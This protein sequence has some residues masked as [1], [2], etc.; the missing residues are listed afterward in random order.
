VAN[1]TGQTIRGY[2]I[3]ERIGS[4]GYGE[5]YRATQQSVG[6]DVAIKVIL[7]AYADQPEFI[8]NFETEARLVAQLEHPA[9]VP[10][11]DYWNDEQGAFLVMR[12]I[13]GGSLRA[14][15]AKQGALPLVR[16]LRVVEQIA[17]ALQVSHEAGVVHRDLKPDNILIDERGNAYLT[18]FGIAKQLKEGSD[19]ASD[20]IKGTFAYLSPEQIQQTTPSAQTDIYAL[21]IILYE[22][23]TGEHPFKDATVMMMV[24]KHLQDPLPIITD[25]R[26]DL[27][28]GI[29][30]VIGRA[31]QKDP[32]AR[33]DSTLAF[34]TDLKQTIGGS[35]P[36][37]SQ[38]IT[39]PPAPRR[40]S[41]PEQRNRY[42]MLQN[43]RK[44]WVEG[45]LEN[46]L[47]N[48]VMLDLDMKSKSGAVDNPWDTL[49]RTPTGDELLSS[50][51]AL[52]D[53]FD[54]M[55]G[56]LLILGDPGGGKTTSLLSL[57]R[58]LLRR[59]DADDHHPIPIILNI[60]SWGDKQLALDEWLVEELNS[61]YQVPRKVGAGW[62]A[63]DEV[64]LLLDGLD[65][66]SENARD[67]CV[68]AINHFRSEHGFVDV[69]VCSRIKDYEALSH[70]L[71]LNG[72]IIIQ[73]LTDDQIQTYLNALGA[74]VA[75]VRDL[76]THDE[77]LREL[78]HTPLMLSIM[79]LA[80]RG[81]SHDTIPNFDTL[82]AQRQHLFS[83]YVERMFNR[84]AIE[85][86]YTQPKTLKYLS[87]LA[88]KMQERATSVFN[89]EE[90]Q[91]IVIPAKNRQEFYRRVQAFHIGTTIFT[92]IIASIFISIAF[93]FPLWLFLIGLGLITGF[94]TGWSYSNNQWKRQYPH[95]LTALSQGI[96]L[97]LALAMSNPIDQS[98]LTSLIAIVSVWGYTKI[99]SQYYLSGGGDKDNIPLLE[100]IQFRWENIKPVYWV[101]IPLSSLS[102]IP[103]VIL[104]PVLQF[105][106][107]NPYIPFFAI[108][109]FISMAFTLFILGGIGFNDVPMRSA[110]NQGVR[111]T[112]RTASKLTFIVTVLAFFGTLSAS[113][114]VGTPLI[115]TIFLSLALS[116]GIF[117]YSTWTVFGGI[118]VASHWILRRTL[119][120]NDYLPANLAQFL[121][122]TASLILMRKVG[123][124]YIFIH[125]YLLEYF[126]GLDDTKK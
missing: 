81:I 19:T 33:Y 89:I 118:G 7:P 45:V 43:V 28:N 14:A 29:A 108:T 82:E 77:Q 51:M 50:D 107:H 111:S 85:A 37:A 93:N 61:K 20:Q 95:I 76:I 109:V 68:K 10:L 63:N 75:I 27:P 23:L 56:K 18:D 3:G 80:Y 69:V 55:N 53:I 57:A 84:R 94:I 119:T 42:A 47:H 13:R 54:R 90:L 1:L 9:I 104:I 39:F 98:L 99:Y 16:A 44:F 125:R 78:A 110:P 21:G 123:G 8:T 32:H 4:G 2:L 25:I 65:E 41:S 117:A 70:Q 60:S 96:T 79:V 115:S 67:N 6:R 97:F 66:V 5:V 124:G 26:P 116:L 87:W 73:P 112:L 101:Y 31:T 120:Y 105:N 36:I 52:I 126:A 49:L 12:Y 71:R 46:S 35:Y 113:I 62:V 102:P 38:V 58:E 22:I 48:T 83:A 15:I 40:S 92:F 106:I 88:Q 86:L 30:D 103:L 64:L 91:P 34:I 17:E 24:M 11:I 72:A 122:Y 100:K 59:A 121:D 114:L 74:D